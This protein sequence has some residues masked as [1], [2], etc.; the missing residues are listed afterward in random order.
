MS[1]GAFEFLFFDSV[2][3]ASND[4]VVPKTFQK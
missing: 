1:L 4:F 3:E 2:R